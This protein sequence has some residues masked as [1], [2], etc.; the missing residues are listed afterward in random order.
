MKIILT[1][2]C[3]L[4][5]A[6]AYGQTSHEEAKKAIENREFPGWFQDAKLGIF[7]HWGLYSVPAYGGK[8]SYSE[9]FLRG[10]QMKDSLR[11]NFLK[12][13]YGENFTYNDLAHE[14]KAELFDPEEWADL[15]KM[16]GA[17]YVVL[18]SKHHDGYA[19]WPSKYNRN[20]NSADNKSKKGYCGRTYRICKGC[21]IKNG[22]VLL[23]ARMESSLAPLVCRS[24]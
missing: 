24:P 4:F 9:W 21:R 11:T 7:V 6:T 13:T 14:F 16:A 3:S 17:K 5:L 2:F 23:L 8:E 10:L 12:N 19:L 1:L 22:T 15:F 20:W 18:V